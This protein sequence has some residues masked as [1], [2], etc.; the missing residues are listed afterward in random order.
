MRGVVG[1]QRQ[2]EALGSI[3]VT[4]DQGSE[5][6]QIG[7]LPDGAA[8]AGFVRAQVDVLRLAVRPA[9][10][11]KPLLPGIKWEIEHRKMQHITALQRGPY[12][13]RLIRRHHG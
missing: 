6:A 7:G 5:I 8:H 4:Q 11:E 2:H 3:G 10:I 9:R 12:G 1:K 13:R